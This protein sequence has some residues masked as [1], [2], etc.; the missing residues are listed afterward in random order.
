[1]E[2]RY[3]ARRRGLGQQA[4]EIREAYADA[5][6]RPRQDCQTQIG[7]IMQGLAREGRDTARSLGTPQ[8]AAWS[9]CD[10]CRP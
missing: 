5:Q 6:E 9:T 3:E 10:L 1:M 7:P 2:D 8:G 4:R